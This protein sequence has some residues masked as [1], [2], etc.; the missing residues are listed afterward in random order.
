MSDNSNLI[1]GAVNEALNVMHEQERSRPT[2][3]KACDKPMIPR[4]GCKNEDCRNYHDPN[5]FRVRK[6]AQGRI[7]GPW[8]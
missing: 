2:N 5:W 8:E 1:W 6:D 4:N 7:F 3:C